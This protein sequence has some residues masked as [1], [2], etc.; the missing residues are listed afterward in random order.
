[1]LTSLSVRDIVLIERLDLECGA[2]LG[3]L[4]GETGAGKS[5]LLD[6]LGLALGRRADAGLVRMGAAQGI[7]TASFDVPPKH[8][9]RA[10]LAEQGFEETDDLV[11]RRVVGQ[12]GK[13]RAFINDQ[14]VSVT[15]L[16]RV[17]DT[18]VEIHGQNDEQG[19]TDATI[20]RALLDEYAG[21]EQEVAGLRDAYQAMRD[22]EKALVEAA[23]TAEQAKREE[24]FL[25]HVVAELEELKPQP[26]EEQELAGQRSMLQAGEKLASAMQEAQSALEQGGGVDA[27]LRACLRALERV[28][29]KAAGKL[30]AVIALADQLLV[31]AGELAAALERTARDLDL[32]PQRLERVEERLFALRAAARKHN[33]LVDDLPKLA[34]QYAEKLALIDHQT[35]SL[36]KLEKAAAAAKAAYQ[37]KAEA[38]SAARRKAAAKLDK[39]V[40]AELAPLK[41]G[42]AKFT[43]AVEALPPEQWSAEGADRVQFLAS[44]NQGTAPGSLAKIASG[45]ELSRFMLALRVVLAGRGSAGTL[46]FDEVDRGVGGATAAAVGERLARLAK[47]VQV[48]VVTHSPQVAAKGSQHWRIAKRETGAAKNRTTLTEVAPLSSGDRREEIARMLAGAT[49]TDAARAAAD[50]LLA[51]QEA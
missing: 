28:S 11:L 3:V 31:Q 29:D 18:L 45:G 50:S 34:E 6:A 13:S 26:G 17:G 20:H 1:M 27:R 5:I 36:G 51:G 7:V 35:A 4:T 40:A 32:D 48:L 15:L 49:I 23:A 19:L 10:I 21:L 42:A 47:R 2:G 8:P 38:I 41:L 22:A 44:T 30:D 43:T 37:A 12:D 25:R 46:I 16:R 33:V 14:P 39:A 24:D 9:A